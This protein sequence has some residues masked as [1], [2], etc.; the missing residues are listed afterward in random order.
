MDD[1]STCSDE[2]RREADLDRRASE[3]QGS[4][5]SE[6]VD[7]FLHN[8]KWWLTPIVLVLLAFGALLVLA[9]SGLG[10]WIYPLI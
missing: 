7:F 3:P 9:G 10:P 5:L 4:I 6:F 1:K 8:K 2:E